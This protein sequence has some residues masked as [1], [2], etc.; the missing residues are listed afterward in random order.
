MVLGEDAHA[1]LRVYADDAHLRLQLSLQQV[2]QGGLYIGEYC[3][4]EHS[5]EMRGEGWKGRGIP[6]NSGYTQYKNKIK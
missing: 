3:T 6:W 2:D 4:G 5:G 1:Q